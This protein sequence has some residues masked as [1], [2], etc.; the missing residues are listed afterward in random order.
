MKIAL[1]DFGIGYS[2]LS[3]LKR[4]PIDTLKLDRSFVDGS[5][6]N[7]NDAALVVA[8]ITLA[9]SFR[10]RVIAEGV[11]TEEQLQFL[12]SLSCDGGQGYLFGRPVP[13]DVFRESLDHYPELASKLLFAVI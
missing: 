1:D 12:H 11:E 9:R 4:L 7:K 10:L 6:T 3:Y 5:T 13:A 2:S 8:V